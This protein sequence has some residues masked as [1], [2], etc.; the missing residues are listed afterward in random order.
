MELLIELSLIVSFL[1][2]IYQ[3][4]KNYSFPLYLV[5]FTIVLSFWHGITLN[6][7]KSFLIN[8]FSN[9]TILIWLYFTVLVYVSIKEK[10][11]ITSISYYLGIGDWLIMLSIC[12]LLP[13]DS[14]VFFLLTANAFSLIIWLMINRFNKS[15]RIPLAGFHGIFISILL[16]L[17]SV[18]IISISKSLINLIC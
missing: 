9:I 6:S 15:N 18:R 16:I 2:I 3:D 10:Q 12:F 11:I 7:S 13:V 8:S 1:L 17:D 14:F 4:F 5:I